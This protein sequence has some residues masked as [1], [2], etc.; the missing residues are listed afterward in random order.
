MMDLDENVMD[1]QDHEETV[2]YVLW[3]AILWIS[4]PSVIHV[5]WFNVSD[6]YARTLFLKYFT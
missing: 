4:V 1:Q 2:G 5:L 6:K 3:R